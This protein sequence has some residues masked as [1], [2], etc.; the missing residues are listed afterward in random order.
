MGPYVVHVKP[1]HA[2]PLW[3]LDPWLFGGA[4]A[5]VEGGPGPGELVEVLD[6]RGRWIARGHYAPDSRIAVRLCTWDPQEQVDDAFW[7]RR[8]EAALRL[9]HTGAAEWKMRNWLTAARTLARSIA[10]LTFVMLPE[11]IANVACVHVASA[12]S[13]KPV[14]DT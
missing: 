12:G 2:L 10:P 3:S 13:A 11:S 14:V 4:V 9:R 6:H 7:R 5:R 1:R 8:L